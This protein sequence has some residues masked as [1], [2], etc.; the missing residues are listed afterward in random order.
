[1]GTRVIIPILVPKNLPPP[2]TAGSLSV[3]YFHH[4]EKGCKRVSP[5]G[6]IQTL[7]ALN[8]KNIVAG[9]VVRGVFYVILKVV[10]SEK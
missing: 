10:K 6:H 7:E 1:M 4:A 2:H 8:I 5:Q 3:S 9:V